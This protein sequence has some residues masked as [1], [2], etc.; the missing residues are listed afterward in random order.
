[1]AVLAALQ[2]RRVVAALGEQEVPRGY[3]TNLGVWANFALAALALALAMAGYFI[4]GS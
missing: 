2:F 3:W 1:M 4:G